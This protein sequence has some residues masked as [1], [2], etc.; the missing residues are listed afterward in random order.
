MPSRKPF[1]VGHRNRRGTVVVYLRRPPMPLILGP[2]TLT[3]VVSAN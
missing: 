1:L 2:W 3:A